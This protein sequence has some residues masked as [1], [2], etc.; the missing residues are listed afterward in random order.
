MI[1]FFRK[2]RQRLLSENKISKYFLYAVGEIVLVVI[3]IL[4]ALQINNW[5]QGRKNDSL[6]KS[7]TENLIEDLVNDSL[8]ISKTL[9]YIRSDSTSIAILEHRVASSEHPL[10]TMYHIAR[11]EYNFYVGVQLDYNDDTYKILTSTG[12]IA[13]FDQDIIKELYNLSNLK[14]LAKNTDRFTV[15]ILLQHYHNYSSKYP[16]RVDHSFVNSGSMIDDMIRKETSLVSHAIDFNALVTAKK[17]AYRIS[18]RELPQ[19]SD[20]TNALLETLRSQ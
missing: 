20:R 17:N 1:K 5:N 19:L 4:I 3:G 9:E 11:F 14:E 8:S 18:Q 16:V 10:D 13:L 7:Y 15:D 12:H 2:I 6:E